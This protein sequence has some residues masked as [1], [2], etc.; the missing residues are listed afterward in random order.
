MGSALGPVF[1]SCSPTYFFIIA[2]VLPESFGIG[3][4][5][6]TSYTIGLVLMLF[7]IALLGRKLITK[8]HWATDSRGWFK[9]GLGILFILLGLAI[10]FGLD[11]E[12][13]ALLL[14]TGVYDFLN[15]ESEILEQVN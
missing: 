9:R 5:Y 14:N 15:F 8:L 6:L 13:E 11:K 2:T 4:I 7:A 3:L 10:A 1:S 12:F